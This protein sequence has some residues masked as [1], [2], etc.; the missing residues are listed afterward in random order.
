VPH[1]QWAHRVG[2][3]LVQRFRSPNPVLAACCLLC[4]EVQRPVQRWRALFAT[5]VDESRP[6]APSSAHHGLLPPRD[7]ELT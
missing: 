6:S 4:L 1:L 3:R 5:L 7:T 2:Q